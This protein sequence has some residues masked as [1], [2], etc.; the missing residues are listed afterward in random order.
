MEEGALFEAYV[1]EGCLNSGKDCFHPAE[2]D[3]ADDPAM[4]RA[5]HQQF[6]EAIVLEDSHA[7]LPL[8]PI[9]KN[10]ALHAGKPRPDVLVPAPGYDLGVQ[11][12]R[13]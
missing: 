1:N 12:V 2:I 8:A 5:V 13:S 6:D 11:S 10:F 4:I 3:V 9:D 7:G